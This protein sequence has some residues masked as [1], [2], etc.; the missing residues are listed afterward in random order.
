VIVGELA[1]PLVLHDVVCGRSRYTFFYSLSLA[2]CHI[3]QVEDRA[4]S[5]A[6]C[7]IGWASQYSAGESILV[8]WVWRSWWDDQ[9]N[10]HS[11]PNWFI[12]ISTPFVNCW[13][14]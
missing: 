5:L 8:V 3:Q 7:S 14:T 10:Y 9:L 4:L 6:S 1:L 11:G 12:P 2:P 13:N